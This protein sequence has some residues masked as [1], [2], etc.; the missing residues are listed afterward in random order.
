MLS[1]NASALKPVRAQRHPGRRVLWLDRVKVF[2]PTGSCIHAVADWVYFVHRASLGSRVRSVIRGLGRWQARGRSGPSS[3]VALRTERG[4]TG[5]VSTLQFVTKEHDV[6]DDHP[7]HL[8]LGTNW[9]VETEPDCP[10]FLSYA[11]VGF[12]TYTRSGP[13]VRKPDE[14]ACFKSSPRS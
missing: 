14:T 4:R 6:V 5:S 3:A 2:L 1:A 9:R 11:I 13:M 10:I 8:F 7:Q 12:D